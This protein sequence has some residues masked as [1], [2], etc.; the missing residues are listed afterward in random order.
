MRKLNSQFV[1]KF[2]S[3]SGPGLV[4]GTYYG[5]VELD[6]YYCAAVAQGYDDGG[7]A[8]SA[9]SAVD[10]VMETF[11]SDPGMSSRKMKRCLKKAHK[12]LTEQSVRF[13]LKAGILLLVSDYTKL[14]YALCGNVVLYGLRGGSVFHQSSTH[15]VYEVMRRQENRPEQTGSRPA[16]TENLYRY[17]GGPFGVIVSP[18][19]KLQ[20]GDVLLLAT[21]GFWSS[22]GRIEVLDAYES[23]KS[24]EEFLEDLQELYL[25]AAGEEAPDFCL[26]AV[27]IRKIYTPKPGLRKKVIFW[28]LL[29]CLL[30]AIGAAV[31]YFSRKYKLAKQENIRETVAL[32]ESAGDTYLIEGS[33]TLAKQQYDKMLEEGVALSD[34]RERLEEEQAAAG[35]QSIGAYLENAQKSY[36]AQDYSQARELYRQALA[37]VKQHPELSALE[38]MIGQKQKLTETGVEIQDYINSASLQEAQGNMEAADALYARAEAMLRIVD[39]P[40]L[41]QQV[42]LSRLRVQEAAAD[43][44]RQAKGKEV[45]ESIL[46]ADESAAVAAVIAGD[47]ATAVEL[48]TQIRDSYI[49]LEENEKAEEIIEILSSLKRQAGQA[50]QPQEE[51]PGGEATVDLL[52]KEA[53][54]LT[55]AGDLAGAV[56]KYE[57]IVQ[58][59]VDIGREDLAGQFQ[60]T[61]EDLNNIAAERGQG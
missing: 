3:D 28:S 35:K 4:N 49:G 14:R 48:Y 51:I 20:E 47:Y 42:R 61:I 53:L 36:E 56:G 11:V 33:F 34:S 7:G 16:E 30:L 41:L 17:L 29:I 32:F 8:D 6:G 43:A 45:E 40:E 54:Q 15:T 37:L 58:I 10:T 24:E 2:I 25:G 5:F 18:K 19:M 23:M 26:G 12:R 52:R 13:R 9:R 21:E 60:N 46:A 39:S 31:F 44:G 1:T 38:G 27:G 57:Q 59:Y 50:P 55:A 22:V